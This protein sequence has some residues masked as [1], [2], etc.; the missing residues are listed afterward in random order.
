MA[1]APL[2]DLTVR[3]VRLL[4]GRSGHADVTDVHVALLAREQDAVIVTSDPH[5]LAQFDPAA[6]LVVV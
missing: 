3:A 1:V 4:C 6:E 2:D 5:D